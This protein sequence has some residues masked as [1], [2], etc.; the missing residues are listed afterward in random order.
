MPTYLLEIGTEELP[1]D[2]VPE[3]QDRLKNLMSEYLT[4]SNVP[5]EEIQTMGTPRRLACIVKGLASLQSTIK[6]KVKGP[7][8]QSSFDDK[9]N[10]LPPALGFAQKQ[11]LTVDQLTREEVGG[12]EFLVADVT[13]EGRPSKEV[14]Q[15]VVPK[16][17][18]GLSGERLM[19][20]GNY[21]LKFSRPIRWLVSLL[22]SD[23]VTITLDFIRS[24]RD[25]FGNRVL[26]PGK[27]AIDS[28]SNYVQKLREAKVLVDPAERRSLIE[29]QVAEAAG[30]V[31]GQPRQLKGSLLNEVTNILE[32]PHAVVGE[33]G[34]EYLDLPDTLIE[35]IMVHH[36]RYF[37]V[38]RTNGAATGNKLLPY[39]I[40]VANND[41]AEATA[42]IKQGNER[43]IKARLADGRFFYFDDQKT[44]LSQRKEALEQ[45]T[46]QEGLGSY[47]KKTERMVKA[48][49]SLSD[50]LK[51]EAKYLV[52]LERT[53]ELCKLD[54]V[55][56]LVRELPEL[57][58]YVGSWYASQ[59]QEP[60]E[61]VAA[62]TSHYAP[63]SQD[64]PI[65][66][67]TTGKL[68]AAVDKLDNLVGLYALGRRPTGSSDP[69]ALRRQAQGLVDI[70]LDGLPEYAIN[71]TALMVLLMDEVKPLLEKKRGFDP[72]KAL[73]D[74]TE[75]LMQRARVKLND[76]GFKR[77]VI[78]AVASN[79]NILENMPDALVRCRTLEG[80]INEDS[81][82]T[83]I[84]AGVRV[85]NILSEQ[86]QDTVNPALFDNESEKVLWEA[87]NSKV[88][89]KEAGGSLNQ[90]ATQDQYRAKLDLLKTIVPEIN[91]F[92]D[93]VLVNDPDL[94]KKNNRHG[95]LNSI[96]KNFAALGDFRKLQPL[97]P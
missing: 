29:K 51:L 92:F 89:A 21:D 35:T 90:C 70:L 76:K 59:E 36:Q 52:C 41:R 19:R 74:L 16:A 81:Q 42:K 12:V 27:V 37:P 85:A 78:D 11:G 6:K 64:D 46:F 72:S 69:Y 94:A 4:Q 83:L 49:R 63:R 2:H 73:L 9:G 84:R 32:W 86:S 75:F 82:M 79:M 15:E 61:V 13:I 45:L 71:V 31:S 67:D 38:E 47:M 7:K 43:V 58:G 80:L 23:E 60:P 3:A 40:A 88:V 22:D 54:L 1:A 68:A 96:N 57:Q 97:L 34:K 48:G 26:A 25:S 87:F 55:S 62:I 33:F 93:N 77:E 65:P 50:S 17:I 44:K 53:L 95:L 24:G 56:N 14:L 28:P 39:F 66:Q 30:T 91:A 10:A 8:V 18:G 5:F 20:W